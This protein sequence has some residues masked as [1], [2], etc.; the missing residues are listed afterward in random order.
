LCVQSLKL[1]YSSFMTETTKYCSF[2]ELNLFV[3]L[4]GKC[5]RSKSG[6]RPWCKECEALKRRVDNQWKVQQGQQLRKGEYNKNKAAHLNRKRK[7]DAA[8]LNRTPVWLTIKDHQ[9]IKDF[10]YLAKALEQVTGEKYHVDHIIPLQGELVSG[11]H[12]PSNLRVISAKENLSKSNK[13][14]V[15]QPL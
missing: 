14:N 3:N 2:C 5:N 9:D 13:F 6:F 11:L 1:C 10:Y 12:V 8:Q 7:R 15:K 4:F